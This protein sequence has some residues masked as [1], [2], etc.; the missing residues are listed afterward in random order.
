MIRP[1]LELD[2][3][4]GRQH[5]GI[6]E[7]RVRAYRIQHYVPG[8]RIE[9]RPVRRQGVPR[10]A[11]SRRHDHAVRFVGREGIFIDDHLNVDDARSGAPPHNDIVQAMQGLHPIHLHLVRFQ[12]LDRQAYNTLTYVPGNP[13]TLQLIATLRKQEPVWFEIG[14]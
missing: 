8:L 2:H 12:I 6:I 10:A 9:Y 5:Q 3:G 7:R 11:R 14:Y 13:A 1:H 4:L